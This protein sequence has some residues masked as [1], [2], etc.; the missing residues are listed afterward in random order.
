MVIRANLAANASDFDWRVNTSISAKTS[1]LACNGIPL[2]DDARLTVVVP[3]QLTKKKKLTLPIPNATALCLDRAHSAFSHANALRKKA[4]I[5]TTLKSDVSFPFTSD[6][7]DFF[8]LRM[9]AVVLAVI[10]IEAFVNESIPDGYSFVSKHERTDHTLTR[11]KSEIERYVTLDEKLA[12]VLPGALARCPTPKGM[13]AWQKYL[14]LRKLRDRLVHLKTEDRKA[15]WPELASVWTDL[16]L[17]LDPALSAKSIIDHFV[18]YLPK[19]P[20][21]HRLYPYGR[22]LRQ[23]RDD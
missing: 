2:S 18:P 3:V 14:L 16:V 4:N 7:M 8:A 10:A 5:D 13:A 15:I 1:G 11:P 6:A 9:E 17:C 23:H 12:T 21:W 19:R 22:C 20:D